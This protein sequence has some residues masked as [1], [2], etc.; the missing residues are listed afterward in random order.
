MPNHITNRLTIVSED[1]DRIKEILEAVKNDKHGLGSIDFNK[2]IAF[3]MALGGGVRLP[4]IFLKKRKG[5]IGK[6]EINIYTGTPMKQLSVKKNMK[7][8]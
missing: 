4:V 7:L 2:L 5:A 1:N 8:Y 3:E 6:I